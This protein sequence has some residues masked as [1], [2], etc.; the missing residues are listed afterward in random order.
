MSVLS[1]VLANHRRQGQRRLC[2][3]AVIRKVMH[4]E[5]EDEAV[6]DKDE[7][8]EDEGADGDCEHD[9]SEDDSS[10]ADG[11][12]ADEKDADDAGDG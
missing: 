7:E 4:W 2:S 12:A 11:E 6:D 8:A 10:S 5:D 9:S 1:A 3:G